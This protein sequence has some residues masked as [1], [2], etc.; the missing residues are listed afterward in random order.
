[1]GQS[2][3]GLRARLLLLVL[4][5][6]LPAFGLIGY[7]AVAQ[8]QAAT[9]HAETAAMNLVRLT[10]R[11]QSQWIA[12][13]RQLL[14]SL[15]RLPAVKAPGDSSCNRL[16]AELIRSYPYYTNFGAATPDGRV[17][18]SAFPLKQPVNIAD[19][20]YFRRAVQARDFGVGDYQVGRITGIPAI[21]FGY[22]ALD[23][24]GNLQAVVYA[25]LNLS[26]L[27]Q[28]TTDI[29]IPAG[30]VLNVA[31][32][33]GTLLARYP[34]SSNWIGKS[35][36]GV[37]LFNAM[38][39]H[40]GAGTIEYV[41]PD[42]V[43]WLYAFAP[44]YG[45]PSGS[46]YVSVGIPK[47][48]AFA[49]AN[50][51]LAHSLTLL[52]AVALLALSAAW[53]GSDV[54]V[55]RRV[56]ALATAAR[57]LAKG[58]LSARTGLPH[59]GEEL[60]QLAQNFDAMAAALQ[61]VNR[62]LKTISAGNRALVRA[63]DEQTLLAEMCRIIVEVGGYC[64]AW[65]GYARQDE[66][67]T[68]QAVAQ[69]GFDSGL[70][71]LADV[72]SAVTWADTLWGR[73]P[74]AIAIRT[75][76]ECI[77]R[78]I[79]IDPDFAPWREEARRR[80]YASAAAFPLRV[81][82]R[83]LGALSIYSDDPDAFDAEEMELLR[84]AAEDLAFGIAGLHM[85]GEHEQVNKTIKHMAYYD[86]LT[87]L[88]NHVHFEEL[89]QRALAEAC[90]GDRSLALLLLD[91]DRFREI[92]DA[93][94]FD[95]GDLLLIDV[96]KRIRGALHENELAA[97]L[98]GDEFAVLLP[99]GDAERAAETARR[100]LAAFETPFVLGDITLDVGAAIGIALFPQHGVE[101]TPLV[102]HL[103]IA[104]RL[105]KKREER[106]AFYTVGGDEGSTRRLVLA[107]ELRCAI[108]KDELVLYYQPKVDM[109]A[110]RVCGVEAL[111]RW[112]HPMHGMMPPDEFIPLAEH[113]GLIKPLTEWVLAT[114]LRQSSVWRSAGLNLPIA[115]NLSARNLR[116]A[117]LLDKMKQLLGAWHADAGWLEFEITESTIMDDPDGALAI[118]TSLNDLGIA[119]FVDD[120]G[121]GYSS[122]SY[123][124]K[125]PVDAVKID[126][127]FVKN[128]LASA[129]SAAI[130]RATITLAHDLGM[131]VVAEGVES[132]EMW[133]GLAQLRCDVA[134]GYFIGAPMPADQL[135]A[136]LGRSPWHPQTG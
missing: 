6:V 89:L 121:T 96:S 26:W 119:L 127:S 25:A 79:L 111:V 58:D 30:S 135:Q 54:F 101:V 83:T 12:S 90:A 63:P 46:V 99:A 118:L 71:V 39:G 94:G 13:T 133:D 3:I 20:S 129:D 34:E 74:G 106:Y 50:Q 87:G 38:L 95:Q 5:A 132:R 22:P 14:L 70:E 92:N 56:K 64:F 104:M 80:G 67:K 33:R 98:R 85:R 120:F 107:R 41:G 93:L 131:K 42:G 15:A 49:A 130:V 122:L 51:V 24:D 81:K 115:V 75:D 43:I 88:P 37:P 52:L 86:S 110:A 45:S 62:A 105:A 125:L 9:L 128:M 102:R 44:L 126:K 28:L 113:T 78:N 19:R 59:G 100:I 35:L 40:G 76:K 117:G 91:L 84:E 1:M 82:D 10:A 72:L 65:V 73:C 32:S 57:R 2:S 116:D 109:R 69:A 68:V 7:M 124:Q 53:V 18:C 134:Q 60:G 123:L 4:A 11:E 47:T 21:N 108:E 23:A 55:L 48:V 114:A 112:M 61:K 29:E 77:M 36:R 16:L 27:N 136:W 17:Y 97:R 8:R 66:G 31:D 103:D